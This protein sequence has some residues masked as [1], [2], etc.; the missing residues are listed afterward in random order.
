MK[1]IHVIGATGHIGSYLCPYLI[2]L[3]YE[4]TGYSRGFS[5]PYHVLA[6]DFNECLV[7]AEREKA[8]E[9][10]LENN[11]D[12][13]CDLIGYTEEDAQYL[14]EK[15]KYYD[16]Y[17]KTRV[18]SIGSIW[19]YGEPQ[20]RA[21]T[22]EDK[23]NP[24]DMYGRNKAKMETYLLEEYCKNGLKVTVLHPGH[25]C[26]KG[27]MPVGPQGN[28]NKRVLMDIKEGKR[29][30]LPDNGQ[31]MLHHVHSMDIA[32]MIH[33]VI[34]C[35]KTIGE[36]FNIVCPQPISLKEYAEVLYEH[37]GNEPQIEYVKYEEFLST[38][39][40]EDAVVSAEHIDHSPNISMKK[41]KSILNFEP[42]YSER[43][44]V[45]EAIDSIIF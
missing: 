13:I 21:I 34:E 5:H 18:I 28:R 15:I 3:G 37:F 9:I 33:K 45:L 38:Q 41:A 8:I 35:D 40:V 14:C 39:N 19:I 22:E 42:L 7:Y 36:V 11:A 31:A 1:K 25:I 32:R 29:I 6:T 2:N 30:I 12:V 44:T 26:G 16:K 20:N 23:R 27:W 24:S 4:V 10:A 43:D 17:N